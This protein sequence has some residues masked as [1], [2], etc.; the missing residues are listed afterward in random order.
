MGYDFR[1]PNIT[2][3]T[4]REQILQI[5]SFLHQLVEQLQFAVNDVSNPQT[6]ASLISQIEASQKAQSMVGQSSSPTAYFSEIKSLIIKSADIVDAYYEEINKRL[7]GVYVAE[8]VFG[9][10]REQTAQDITGTSTEVNRA[11][12][13]IQE[14]TETVNSSVGLLTDDISALDTELQNTQS[15]VSDGIS[16][17]DEKLESVKTK[18][19]TYAN[20]K[21]GLL[22]YDENGVAVYGVE[23]GQEDVVNGEKRYKR[24]AR[25]IADRLSFFDQNDVEVAYI[26]NEKL[27]ITHAEVKGNLKIGGYLI[28]T[29]N[30]L[31]FKWVGRG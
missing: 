8:S 1:F 26:S 11:F 5:K 31:T 12:T 28:D 4:E 29:T 22:Y 7:E 20:I 27:Y 24:F 23:V 13:N 25:F 14:V 18:V 21:S 16:A 2:G 19:E 15:N 9:T 17:L 30:G 6:Q 3:T 10:F